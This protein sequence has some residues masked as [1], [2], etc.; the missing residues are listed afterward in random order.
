MAARVRFAAADHEPSAPSSTVP[1]RPS[2]KPGWR[3]AQWAKPTA[4][5]VPR[6]PVPQIGFQNVW[7]ASGPVAQLHE[8]L[9]APRWP[10]IQAFA[11]VR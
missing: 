11:G 8:R 5:Q 4:K 7:P 6:R 1:A 2:T 3:G 9:S 10:P